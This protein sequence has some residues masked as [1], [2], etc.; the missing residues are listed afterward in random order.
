MFSSV[1]VLICACVI[2]SVYLIQNTSL[3]LRENSLKRSDQEMGQIT[4][5]YARALNDQYRV[6]QEIASYKL[7]TDYLENTPEVM[8]EKYVEFTQKVMPWIMA[9]DNAN[10]GLD[11]KIYMTGDYQSIASFIGG[12]ISQLEKSAWWDG[13]KPGA[14]GDNVAFAHMLVNT[15]YT[16]AVV[17]YRNIYGPLDEKVRRVVSVSQSSDDLRA[18]IFVEDSWYYLIDDGGRIVST[19]QKEAQGLSMGE[20]MA[21]L[22][23]Q[24]GAPEDNSFLWIQG[25]Q[26][27]IRNEPIDLA[28]AGIRGWRVLY[29]QSYG[30]IANEIQRQILQCVWICV[31]IVLAALVIAL[32]VARNITSRLKLLMHKITMLA[33]GDFNTQVSIDGTD[34]LSQISRQ[35]DEMRASIHQ[36]LQARQQDYQEKLEYERRQKELM[37][38]WRDMEYQALR[39]QINPHYLFNTLES[40]RMSLLLE[41]ER[42]AAR[43]IRIF[44]ETMRRYMD[45]E[46]MSSTLE[47]ELRYLQYY[48]EIQKFRMGDRVTYVEHVDGDLR[49]ED[50]PC[51]ILQPLVENAFDHGIDP[52]VDGGTVTLDI[53]RDGE[54]MVIRVSDDGVGMSAGRLAEVRRGLEASG[55]A[56]EHLGLKNINRRLILLFGEGGGMHIDSEEGKGTTITVRFIIAGKGEPKDV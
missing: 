41:K 34:E 35:F 15:R 32:S 13:A 28:A 26:Y 53:R 9:L 2:V 12:K 55:M 18:D 31:M 56:G 43:I 51:L 17:Y 25:E 49:G 10:P 40:I 27:Y 37:M 4:N 36:L 22:N 11:M 6:L 19:N 1:V 48:I 24:G 29:M 33:A 38:N 54:W 5:G 14:A 21:L 3:L 16:D 23:L 52:K 46:R 7:L 44:A 45:A 39:A 20:L 50:V 42:E 8:Y 30:D 47:E